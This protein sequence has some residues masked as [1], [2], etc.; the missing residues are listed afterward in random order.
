MRHYWLMYQIALSKIFLKTVWYPNS[1]KNGP[2]ECGIYALGQLSKMFVL[3]RLK[4]TNKKGVKRGY[5]LSLCF[6]YLVLF[7]KPFSTFIIYFTCIISFPVKLIVDWFFRH[8]I[9]IFKEYLKLLNRLYDITWFGSV[10]A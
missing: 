6:V 2:P 10:Y 5:S 1:C 9:Y 8:C 3:I 7:Y 4:K